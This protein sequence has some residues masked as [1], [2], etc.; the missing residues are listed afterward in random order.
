MSALFI[1]GAGTD[2]GKTFVCAGLLRHLRAAGA[3]ARAIKPVASG[4]D[5]QAAA[6][7]DAG[8]LLAAMELP[9]SAE[10]IA[11]ICPWRFA[12]PLSP[13]IAARREGRSLHLAEL[14][15]FCR[16]RMAQAPGPLLIEGAGGLMSPV[17]EDA[18]GLDWMR[19]LGCPALLVAGTYLGA[20]S[21]AL[22]AAAA[23]RGA[24]LEL[25]ALAVSESPQSSVSLAE[26]RAALARFLPG[27]AITGIARDAKSQGESF[28]A[29]A[30][31]C[32]L[33]A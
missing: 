31:A 12:A 32:G 30:S 26:T 1:A 21:H 18:T 8:V 29:L 15:A 22:T 17:A 13:D 27:A 33:S 4:F 2:I 11:A 19:A 5:P 10:N 16:A 3:D 20:I 28:R 9:A 6:A 23:M 7:S 14:A 24:G 25:R